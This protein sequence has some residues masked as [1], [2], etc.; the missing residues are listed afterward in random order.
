MRLERLYRYAS[1]PAI[2][3]ERLVR[4]ADGHLLYRLKKRWRDGTKYVVFEPLELMEK[5]AAFVPPVRFKM[6]R[7][8]GVLAL[9]ASW[10]RAVFPAPTDQGLPT[11]PDCPE[12]KRSSV[13]QS[14]IHPRNYSWDELMKRVF[15]MDVLECPR[16]KRRM[17]ILCA[18]NPPEAIRRILDCLR[19]PSHPPPIV[20]AKFANQSDYF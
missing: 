19:Q 13:E 17:R 6:V 12:E 2:A 20:P 9:S 11:H 5:L 15:S 4:L 7:Y 16:C 18:I 14:A 10:R 8:H 3:A 1:R